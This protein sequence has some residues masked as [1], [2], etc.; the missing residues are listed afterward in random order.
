[1]KY[2]QPGHPPINRSPTSITKVVSGTCNVIDT[3]GS[4]NIQ[5]TDGNGDT[6]HQAWSPD[7][8]RLAYQSDRDGNVDIYSFDL[9]I[10]EEYRVTDD[11]GR[12]IGPTWD[13]SGTLLAYTAENED[14]SDIFQV[15]WKGGTS[16]HIT[17]H[18]AIDQWSEWSPAKETASRDE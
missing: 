17:N 13:C 18:P 9:R 5:I 16:S 14:T 4:N 1:M 15:Y 6:S 2:H 10:D 11:E 7:G 8:T 3:D 12:D